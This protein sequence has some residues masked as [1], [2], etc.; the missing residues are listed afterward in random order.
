MAL[1]NRVVHFDYLFIAQST[2]ESISSIHKNTKF[3]RSSFLSFANSR[4]EDLARGFRQFDFT[5]YNLIIVLF[6]E[7]CAAMLPP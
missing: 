7:R 4:E 5:V 1:M 3:R 2:R 6:Y